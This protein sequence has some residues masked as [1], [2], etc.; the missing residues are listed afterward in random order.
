MAAAPP[1]AQ[2]PFVDSRGLLTPSAVQFLTSLQ[3]AVGGALVIDATSR[4]SGLVS[5]RSDADAASHGVVLNELYW[6]GSVL[7]ARRV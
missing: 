4:I 6:N 2:L 5:A 1:I 3:A 7:Q